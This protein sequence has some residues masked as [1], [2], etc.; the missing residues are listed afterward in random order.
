MPTAAQVLGKFA[1][2]LK[3]TDIPADAVERAKDCMIDAIADCTFGAQLPWSRMVADYARRYGSGGPCTVIGSSERVHAP[4]AALANGVFAHA[5]E[6]DS[7]RDPSVGA[8]PGA[9]LTPAV[10]A[11]CEETKADGKTAITAFVASSCRHRDVAMAAF[12]LSQMFGPCAVIRSCDPNALPMPETISASCAPA[13]LS[14]V[15]MS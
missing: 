10:L 14:A 11:A 15:R 5:F 13:Q 2:E 8:H 3:Y 6:H 12:G 4:Y 1:A 7:F 9:T